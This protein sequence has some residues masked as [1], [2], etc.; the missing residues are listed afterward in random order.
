MTSTPEA[1]A[2]AGSPQGKEDACCGCTTSPNDNNNNNNNSSNKD[3]VTPLPSELLADSTNSNNYGGSNGNSGAMTTTTTTT[4]TISSPISSPA[5]NGRA[6]RA[7][8]YAHH[9]QTSSSSLSDFTVLE[10][11]RNEQT[12]VLELVVNN[13][14]EHHPEL[15]KDSLVVVAETK[16]IK[17]DDNVLHNI[18]TAHNDPDITTD[19]NEFTLEEG[20]FKCNNWAG[21]KGYSDYIKDGMRY[22]DKSQEKVVMI[23]ESPT[24][25]ATP[26]EKFRFHTWPPAAPTAGKSVVGPCRYASMNGTSYPVFLK[27]GAP[28]AG[29][30]EHWQRAIPNFKSPTYL[31]Q[32]TDA[33]TA[34]CY[35]PIEDIQHHVND[36]NV[37]YHLAGKDAIHLMTQKV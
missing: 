3:V 35:L 36:P 1:A 9:R 20:K 29:L 23:F 34:Y 33:E 32:I 10:L 16:K 26:P 14:P 5:M 6:G 4:T 15:P 18:V 28:P 31:D 25:T 2:P 22:N 30:Q 19:L 12:D 13:D 17:E 27:D 11:D 8:A 7:E 37:H 21:K 24:W